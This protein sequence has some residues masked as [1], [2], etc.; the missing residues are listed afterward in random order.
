MDG[1]VQTDAAMNPGNSGGPLLDR[2]GNVVGINTFRHP[3]PDAQGVSFAVLL[4]QTC[5]AI[6]EPPCSF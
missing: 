4:D 6:F 5:N 3:H 2:D 1:G